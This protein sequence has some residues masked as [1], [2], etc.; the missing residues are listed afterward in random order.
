M[1]TMREVLIFLAGATC[2]DTISHMLLAA[3]AKLPLDFTF[4]ILTPSLNFW[5]IIINAT[6]TVVLLIW[7]AKLPRSK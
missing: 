3:Y 7:A 5:A 6:L 1:F 2:L 4:I